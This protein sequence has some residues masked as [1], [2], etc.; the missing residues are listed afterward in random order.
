MAEPDKK[1][2]GLFGDGSF[3]MCMGEME[4]LVRLNCPAVL[5]QF[6]NSCFGWIKGLHRMQGKGANDCYSVD[7]NNINAAKIAENFGLKSF[8]VE[9][10]EEFETA[11]EEA[12]LH[13]GPCFLDVV[14]ES[15]AERMPH[16]KLINK[17]FHRQA[18]FNNVRA[19]SSSDDMNACRK[20]IT[21]NITRVPQYSGKRGIQH[22]YTQKG[23]FGV[24]RCQ[25]LH[26]E[27]AAILRN[28]LM[29]WSDGAYNLSR[30]LSHFHALRRFLSRHQMPRQFQRRMARY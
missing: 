21:L 26:P 20:I 23:Y 17:P 19:V 5:I 22:Q 15:F 10:L 7:I 29:Y 18:V 13:D 8:Q 24:F 25:I 3:N 14:V 9:T 16:H 11:F 27:P 4:T 12:L 30:H 1:P 6:N 2:I 28:N